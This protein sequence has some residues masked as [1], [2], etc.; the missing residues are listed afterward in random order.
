MQHHFRHILL[1]TNQFSSL[2]QIQE[3]GNYTPL[4]GGGVVDLGAGYRHICECG[5]GKK[6][7]L[8]VYYLVFPW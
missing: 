8:V 4:L 1:V 7:V 5:S 2:P 6:R 3:E